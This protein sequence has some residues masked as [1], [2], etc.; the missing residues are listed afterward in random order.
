MRIRILFLCVFSFFV[1]FFFY[2]Q[3]SSGVDFLREKIVSERL[4]F[5][6]APIDAK[7]DVVWKKLPAYNG[8]SIDVEQSLKRMKNNGVWDPELLVYKQ[9]APT[10]H[11][12]DLP[13]AP[14]FRG[15]F[16]KPIVALTINVAWGNE[17]IPE[18]LATLKRNHVHASFFLEGKW[19][20]K[21][22]AVA[23]MII[24]EGHEIGNHSYS[25]PNMTTLTNQQI[26][27]QILDTNAILA[28][29]TKKPI[30]YFS[31]PSGTWNANSVK[32]VHN[33]GLETVLWTC[34]TIDWQKPSV[35]KI[36]G[37]LKRK[38]NAGGVILMHPTE[39]S[40]DALQSM[41]HYIKSNGWRPGTVSELLD[42]AYIFK[43]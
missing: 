21:N 5:E 18:M 39:S 37:R 8:I 23:K 12:K 19:T 17:Y 34:D 33:L 29:L 15:Q 26:E 25:H 40:R 31:P 7:I 36:M 14:L 38:L 11:L 24:E 22:S 28:T 13:S 10:I 6:K 27:Q 32:V 42:E 43:K 16:E 2:T 30:Q 1:S 20:Q 35:E 9:K 3:K 41:I 4:S